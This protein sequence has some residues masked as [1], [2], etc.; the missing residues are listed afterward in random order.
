MLLSSKSPYF[1]C[2]CSCSCSS[3]PSLEKSQPFI[4]VGA[5]GH[6][7]NLWSITR[8]LGWRCVGFLDKNVTA[9]FDVP[10]LGPE[11]IY[12]EFCD[13]PL[14]M[15]IGGVTFQD[16]Q[17]RFS[18]YQEFSS[19]SFLSLV[20]PSAAVA[21]DCHIAPGVTI[22]HQAVVNTNAVIEE[23]A[24]INTA[25]VVEHD[26]VVETGAHICPGAKV[27]GG[28]RVGRC[29]LVGSNAV[30]LPQASVPPCSLVSATS[31]F[32]RKLLCSE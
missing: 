5:G 18:L 16:L 14:I 31:I 17:K 20:A 28:A 27:L 23:A 13:V 12:E 24:I 26:A 3:S 1:S 19:K 22:G 2:S 6:A 8:L 7:R 29:A 10:P 32:P 4:F 11:S 9:F 30:V 21:L 15:A 25:A